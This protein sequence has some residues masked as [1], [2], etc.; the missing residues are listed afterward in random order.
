MGL[1][2]FELKSEFSGLEHRRLPEGVIDGRTCSHSS[3][4]ANKDNLEHE[5]LIPIVGSVSTVTS[6]GTIGIVPQRV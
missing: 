4:E 1:N 5:A 3:C 2:L 6:W